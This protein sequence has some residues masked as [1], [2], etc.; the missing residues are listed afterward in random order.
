M[1]FILFSYATGGASWGELLQ[2]KG[3]AGGSDRE[4]AGEEVR[5]GAAHTGA[6]HPR[7]VARDIVLF[8]PGLFA[9]SPP[10]L[11]IFV[12][13]L[14]F[15]V[16]F[17]SPTP[18]YQ[19]GTGLCWHRRKSRRLVRTGNSQTQN[20]LFSRL[21]G[22]VGEPCLIKAEWGCSVLAWTSP[23]LQPRSHPFCMHF[24]FLQLKWG[25]I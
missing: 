9:V 7:R 3:P 2:F 24:L 19:P 10:C 21:W 22:P 25:P 13:M 15:H 8:L 12:R 23:V 6:G 5:P 4:D 1:H 17:L 11:P 20:G 14:T 18:F 16:P